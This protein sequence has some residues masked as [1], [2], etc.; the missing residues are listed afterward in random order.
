[1]SDRVLSS[2]AAREAIQK[3]Q[4]IVNGPLLDQIVALNRQGSVLSQPDVWDGRLAGEFRNNWPEINR[5]L[6]A[7]KND[8]ETLRS[9]LDS[10]NKNI[11]SAGGN[12]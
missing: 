7:I 6:E 10:I 3:F 1:M 12:S 8:L 9:Q 2:A 5:K 4:Q 11:M